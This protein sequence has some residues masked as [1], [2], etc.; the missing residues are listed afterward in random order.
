[1]RRQT[2]LEFQY[3]FDFF[4][5]SRPSL[6]RS[7]SHRQREVRE[8][9]EG[10]RR[11]DE[12]PRSIK[13]IRSRRHLPHFL[14]GAS[15]ESRNNTMPSRV[16]GD[17]FHAYSASHLL[18]PWTRSALFPVCLFRCSLIPVLAVRRLPQRSMGLDLCKI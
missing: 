10:A 16:T 5:F 8:G 1:M 9:Q 3:L 6:L 14:H 15:L 4:G 13:E 7:R 17:Q 2:A 18:A 11:P 12:T